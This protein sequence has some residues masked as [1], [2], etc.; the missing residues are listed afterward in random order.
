M[1]KNSEFKKKKGLFMVS[2]V[3]IPNLSISMKIDKEIIAGQIFN[4]NKEINVYYY[5]FKDEFKLLDID[6]VSFSYKGEGFFFKTSYTSKVINLKNTLQHKYLFIFNC[7]FEKSTENDQ[8]AFNLGSVLDECLSFL[9]CIL[10]QDIKIPKNDKKGKKD[11]KDQS[12]SLMDKSLIDMLEC[13]RYFYEKEC[14]D[15]KKALGLENICMLDFYIDKL[16]DFGHK[17]RNYLLMLTCLDMFKFELLKQST[18]LEDLVVCLAETD[19]GYIKKLASSI[20]VKPGVKVVVNISFLKQTEMWFHYCYEGC[21][22]QFDKH[23]IYSSLLDCL[24]NNG[25]T[26]GELETVKNFFL[27]YYRENELNLNISYGSLL[28]AICNLLLNKEEVI[29]FLF[30]Q[31]SDENYNKQITSTIIEKTFKDRLNNINWNDSNKKSGFLIKCFLELNEKHKNKDNALNVEG[32]LYSLI[33]S[34][35]C[36]ALILERFKGL[37]ANNLNH[38]LHN[39]ND[40]RLRDYASL[41]ELLR[42][43]PVETRYLVIEGQKERVKRLIHTIPHIDSDSNATK[44]ILLS[45]Y[46]DYE[47]FIEL[48]ENFIKGNLNLSEI[49]LLIEILLDKRLSDEKFREMISKLA[50]NQLKGFVHVVQTMNTFFEIIKLI[51]NNDK[52]VTGLCNQLFDFFLNKFGQDRFVNIIQSFNNNAQ[53]QGIS[54]ENNFISYLEKTYSVIKHFDLPKC[55]ILLEE[56]CGRESKII[57]NCRSEEI[58]VNLLLNNLVRNIDYNNL[59]TQLLTLRP[60]CYNL[61]SKLLS[62]E[63]SQ[64]AFLR[65]E[66]YINLKTKLESF[67]NGLIEASISFDT[68]YQLSSL[69]NEQLISLDHILS[70]VN[71]TVDYHKTLENL[72]LKYNEVQSTHELVETFFRNFSHKLNDLNDYVGN[73][74]ATYRNL[75][76]LK[77]NLR[78]FTLEKNLDK[79]VDRFQLLNN[80]NE[81]E[82]FKCHLIRMFEENKHA[83]NKKAINPSNP[84]RINIADDKIELEE[85]YEEIEEEIEIDEN[86]DERIISHRR[87]YSQPIFSN[88]FGNS[89]RIKPGHSRY[90]SMGKIEEDN[91][92]ETPMGDFD[93]EYKINTDEFINFSLNIITEIEGTLTQQMNDYPPNIKLSELSYFRNLVD[94]QREINTLTNLCKLTDFQIQNLSKTVANMN[95]ANSV[96]RFSQVM[97]E[98]IN[99]YPFQENNIELYIDVINGLDRHLVETYYN[100]FEHKLRGIEVIRNKYLQIHKDLESV[101]QGIL[102]ADDMLTFI[103]SNN[104]S[105]LRNLIY[106]V[107]ELSE[108]NIRQ[109][110][111]M[112]LLKIDNFVRRANLNEIKKFKS[113]EEFINSLGELL[114]DHTY[115]NL[116][117]T[118]NSCIKK[119]QEIK[120][121]FNNISNREEACRI[122]TKNILTSSTFTFKYIKEEKVYDFKASYTNS[123]KVVNELTFNDLCNLRDRICIILTNN[124]IDQAAIND[125][126]KQT[127]DLII[128]ILKQLN[129]MVDNGYPEYFNQ[130]INIQDR[131]LEPLQNFYNYIEKANMDWL[132]EREITFTDYY[133]LT[134]LNGTQ[135]WEVE[136]LFEECNVKS[137]GY[138]LLKSIYP[139][140]TEKEI[141]D[142]KYKASNNSSERLRRLGVVLSNLID[143]SANTTTEILLK[144]EIKLNLKNSKVI[145]SCPEAKSIYTTLLSINFNLSGLFPAVSHILYCRHS[146]SY[147]ELYSFFQRFILC[148]AEKR[149]FTILQP[150]ELQFDLQEYIF[151]ALREAFDNIKEISCY[152]SIIC[153][154]KNNPFYGHLHQ[155]RNVFK[156]EYLMDSNVL[157][158]NLETIRSYVVTSDSTGAGKSHYIRKQFRPNHKYENFLI[159]DKIDIN[160]I[161]KRFHNLANDLVADNPIHITISGKIDDFKLLD[162]FLFNILILKSFTYD[163]YASKAETN[164][165]YVEI[166]NSFNNNL[167]E[168]ANVLKLIPSKIHLTSK[169][170]IDNFDLNSNT[171]NIQ[172]VCNY[173]KAISDSKLDN[174]NINPQNLEIL[175]RDD[176]FELL[177]DQFFNKRE[178][179]SFKQLNIFINILADQFAKFSTSFYYSVETL[180]ENILYSLYNTRSK[181][182]EVLLMLPHEF[183][184]RSIRQ[185]TDNQNKTLSLIHKDNND[186]EYSNVKSWTS[187]NHLLVIFDKDGQCL[188][189]IFKDKSELP[190]GVTELA[191]LYKTNLDDINPSR[192]KHE[193]FIEKLFSIEGRFQHIPK[194]VKNLN[195]KLTLDNFIKMILILIRARSKVPIVIMGET[196]CGKTSLIR[197]LTRVVLDED[198]EV[199]NFH[200]GVTKAYIIERME[201]IINKAKD[202]LINVNTKDKRIWV[203]LDE[204]NTCDSL[205]LIA[206]IICQRSV[207]GKLIPD[208]IVLVAACNP[209]RLRQK[210]DKGIGLVKQ[211]NMNKLVYTVN[212]L[213]DTI[214]DYVWDYGSL[215]DEDER[216]YI[217]TI[218]SDL[219][220]YKSL[221]INLVIEAQKFIKVAEGRYSVSL[222]DIERFRILYEWFFNILTVKSNNEFT[223]PNYNLFYPN[224]NEKN[225]QLK[226]ILLAM[227]MCYYNRLAE[228]SLKNEFYIKVVKKIV[229]IE[230]KVFLDMMKD[231]Q[232]DILTRMELPPGIALNS[233]I[234]E[235]VFT[236]IVCALNKIPLFICG[237]PGCS[238][239]LA[240]QLVVSNIRGRFSTDKFFQTLPQIAPHVY[241]GSES[242]TSE[243]IKAVFEKAENAHNE[244]QKQN[245]SGDRNEVIQMIYFDEI[246]LAEISKNNP[247]KILHSLL[248]PEEPKLAFV[249]ISNWKLDA[250]K[251]NRAIYLSRPDLDLIDLISS[252]E[253][254]FKFYMNS[255]IDKNFI[256]TLAQSYTEFIQ[257]YEGIHLYGT[258]DFYCLVKQIAKNLHKASTSKHVSKDFESNIVKMSINRNFG[259]KEGSIK[260]FI[261]TFNKFSGEQVYSEEETI[262]CIEL[263]NDNLIDKDSRF[264]LVFTSGDSASYILEKHLKNRLENRIV[265]IGSEFEDDKNHEGYMFK[266][267]SDIILYI[268]SGK[269][270]IMKNLDSVYGALYDLFNQNYTIV[271]KKKNC[272]I[273]LGKTNNPMCYVNDDFHCIVIAEKNEIRTMDPPFLNRFEKQLL[274]FDNILTYDQTHMLQTLKKWIEDI[275]YIND[276]NLKKC[277]DLEDL[278]VGYSEDLELLKNLIVYN[279]NLSKGEIVDKIK[280]DI[281]SISNT[282]LLLLCSVSEI[283]HRVPGEKERIYDIYFNKQQHE[284]LN[285]HIKSLP[286]RTSNKLIIYTYSNYLSEIDIERTYSTICLSE[287]KTEKEFDKKLI[288]EFNNDREYILIKIN[289]TTETN[290]ISYILF[291]IT[292]LIKEYE[293]KSKK[294]LNANLAL[295]IYLSRKE[296]PNQNL[297]VLFLSDWSQIF[298]EYLNGAD[299]NSLEIFLTRNSN[300]ILSHYLNEKNI[301][302]DLLRDNIYLKFNF[303]AFNKNDDHLIEAYK[304][305]ILELF[306]TNSHIKRLINNKLLQMVAATVDNNQLIKDLC[307]RNDI[308]DKS[309]NFNNRITMLINNIISSPLLKIIYYL[310]H[311]NATQP[312]LASTNLDLVSILMG[313]IFESK[314]FTNLRPYEAAQS[315]GVELIFYLKYPLTKKELTNITGMTKTNL[316]NYLNLDNNLYDDKAIEELQSVFTIFRNTFKNHCSILNLPADIRSKEIIAV[317]IN[318]IINYF[319]TVELKLP[320]SYVDAFAG[321]MNKLFI[322]NLNNFEMIYL[323]LWKNRNLFSILFETL[324]FIETYIPTCIGVAFDSIKAYNENSLLLDNETRRDTE[325]SIFKDMFNTI[326]KMIVANLDNLIEQEGT[327]NKILINNTVQYLLSFKRECSCDLEGFN[328]LKILSEFI[329]LFNLISQNNFAYLLNVFPNDIR[330]VDLKNYSFVPKMFADID[331][332]L[333]DLGTEEFRETL[334]SSKLNIFE[335]LISA[336]DIKCSDNGVEAD[337]RQESIYNLLKDKDLLNRSSMLMFKL[338][339][340]YIETDDE[341]NDYKPTNLMDLMES[342]LSNVIDYHLG[343][344]ENNQ[345]IYYFFIDFFKGILYQPKEDSRINFLEDQFNVFIE[346]IGLLENL[347]QFNRIVGLSGVKHY[348]EIFAM[349]ISNSE[350]NLTQGILTKVN[351][352]LEGKTNIEGS[353]IALSKEQLEVFRTYVLKV[354]MR[355]R[356]CKASGLINYNFELA[357]VRWIGNNSFENNSSALGIETYIPTLEN[358]WRTHAKV[359]D[360]IVNNFNDEENRNRFRLFIREARNNPGMKFVFIQFFILKVYAYFSNANFPHTHTYLLYRD[361]F[362]FYLDEITENLGQATTS[363][364]NNLVTNFKTS[365]TNLFKVSPTT[366]FATLSSLITILQAFNMILC[367]NNLTISQ[368]FNSRLQDFKH[369]KN[370]YIPGGYEDIADEFYLPFIDNIDK[371]YELYGYSIGLYECQCGYLY[372][373]LDCTRP[374]Q[375]STCPKCRLNIGAQSMHVLVSTS[376]CLT[377]IENVAPKDSLLNYLKSK[378]K[379]NPGF[380][381]KNVSDLMNSFTLRN[382]DITGF[383]F[384]NMINNGILLLLIENNIIQDLSHFNALFKDERNVNPLQYFEHHVNSDINILSTILNIND[385]HITLTLLLDKLLNINLELGNNLSLSNSN[386]RLTYEASIKSAFE[387]VNDTSINEYKNFYLDKSSFS[388]INILDEDYNEDNKPSE[389]TMMLRPIKIGNWDDLLRKFSVI[390]KKYIFLDM[391][392]NRFD[393]ISLLSNLAPIINL[394]NYM[395]DKY[396]HRLKRQEAKDLLIR[397]SIKDENVSNLFEKFEEAWGNISH[398]ITQ[399]DCKELPVG[400]I[401]SNKCLAFLL[402]DNVELGYGLYMCAAFQYLGKI[403]NNLLNS[404]FEIVE[405]NT[406]YT[407]QFIINKTT[408]PIQKIPENAIIMN[409]QYDIEF[410]KDLYVKYYTIYSNEIGKGSN[411]EYN[412]EKIDMDIAS[413]FFLG[414][415]KVDCENYNISKIQYQFELLSLKGNS[416]LITDIIEKIPQKI[417]DRDK[418]FEVTTYLRNNIDSRK[419]IALMNQIFR[420]LDYILCEIKYN[421]KSKTITTLGEMINAIRNNNI[422]NP[423]LRDPPFNSL[424]LDNIIHLYQIVEG[425]MFNY[426]LPS[427]SGEYSKPL[428][429]E[430]NENLKNYFN[431]VLNNERYPS[432]QEIKPMLERF[433]LRYLFTMMDSN[434]LKYYISRTDLWN[435]DTSE[436]KMDNF[437]DNLPEDILLEHSRAVW[438]LVR[439][440]IEVNERT[441]VRNQ[442]FEKK[443]P[444]PSKKN[445]IKKKLVD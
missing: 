380:Y 249:G 337:I 322:F 8:L 27:D 311:I 309:D 359:F 65:H 24:K 344:G 132:K 97:L 169:N 184:T 324:Q 303:S 194:D 245:K 310:E 367:Y 61:V 347:S 19:E 400:E 181:I 257:S 49:R 58:F 209:Y 299:L 133:P 362:N 212:A 136:S 25:F 239:S 370:I 354:L 50:D 371:Q 129:S 232:M 200:A 131:Y 434:P 328:F 306:Y 66:Y 109:T 264:M 444:S 188:N 297:P 172:L 366:P 424:G 368:V 124:D 125:Q 119:F 327:F 12:N 334:I 127:V 286:Q 55:N 170:E 217:E 102:Q 255:N 160:D 100:D 180:K 143:L 379:N 401:N 60:E 187:S 229:N 154:D 163:I 31:L 418:C 2:R 387:K 179:A 301:I 33:D 353:I 108:S 279:S 201:L 14:N 195:Y 88:L 43:A 273:S 436:D 413:K 52:V 218:L 205:G 75:K 292:N 332:I 402:P 283:N 346:Y 105:D 270:I 104:E 128:D 67:I 85:E 329:N 230:E 441:N 395:T 144:D 198:F 111:I 183:I 378:L 37:E 223:N 192:F 215:S 258:R 237:K 211:S 155:N 338:F 440:L 437:R 162:Y 106:A 54:L 357:G 208:N 159:S 152:L 168:L 193:E 53:Y 103:Y 197:F 414:K 285:H 79:L 39:L 51:N 142:R 339:K 135:F 412:F 13:L 308:V 26:F 265:L 263:V 323:F 93:E 10:T 164:T 262:N 70:L 186:D 406:R 151:N 250:S 439:N 396:N 375:K 271:N 284:S 238:K 399:F 254:I 71:N 41:V 302:D 121:M 165:I 57:S 174:T 240:V 203:F 388:I 365:R 394:T 146:T 438:E 355:E 282:N 330:D 42:G 210:V 280:Y 384:Q 408:Y 298:L 69:N 11:A 134:Y 107:D 86:G 247:L 185:V 425:F 177:K 153:Y 32:L 321:F 34:F 190:K 333:R 383:R 22:P 364:I 219:S 243:G 126:F 29:E 252:G 214:L 59:F 277:F 312:L 410:L 268:E 315:L 335:F 426:E 341:S 269:S 381:H 175:N 251:M 427:L 30:S 228:R 147:F 233:A 361:I 113:E 256:R 62:A 92:E 18:K 167:Y 82:I 432:L 6:K 421:R 139:N 44:T 47:T 266:I 235:N 63:G 244:K 314:V 294:T 28:K 114:N 304:D 241:Q 287:L 267:L 20:N 261:R 419:N 336:K 178:E 435:L 48:L 137:Y 305:N 191:K 423:Y 389:L 130:S 295:V 84:Q 98:I 45:E 281:L 382:N 3:E 199:I 443:E 116:D 36:L 407:E 360:D 445:N 248:E 319:I 320:N 274:T 392:I 123:H 118:I 176:I 91:E 352:V 242:S 202:N 442:A 117:I 5:P 227:S 422:I 317:Y 115:E 9:F 416:S 74:R 275:T 17:H 204:I 161:A 377:Y 351:M 374:R 189:Y 216:L 150:E 173:L 90:K 348:L 73:F 158:R 145:L 224:T 171:T 81:T 429:I 4:L 291:R 276:N 76:V 7:P 99:K 94:A 21:F 83:F 397:D 96:L 141:N 77:L 40:M 431:T 417:M 428:S 345:Y 182:A 221:A 15:S 207:Q 138:N 46:I 38:V 300:E 87:S 89:D 80:W 35:N 149:V 206:D 120:S 398:H 110:D 1:K 64:T 393:E 289:A 122:K 23:E 101:L 112:E 405:T 411:I 246:G 404:F 260:N 313:Q 196:G 234:L 56:A 391:L 148:K 95:N 369:F 226:T 372:Q 350:N 236:L 157:A 376:K 316:C 288:N 415:R 259:G 213:P 349:Y 343:N 340:E 72:I 296:K 326:V 222:R 363:L 231:E 386:N 290:F 358:S 373:I 433:I 409:E 278:I 356:A 342:T 68:I 385:I 430:A 293:K 331:D 166:A 140:I 272:R 390:P 225:L 220:G 403:Q 253:E 16:K 307:F 318:D 156:N 325:I 78:E 420:S